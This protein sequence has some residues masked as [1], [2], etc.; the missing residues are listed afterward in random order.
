M[1]ETERGRHTPGP[2]SVE[3]PEPESGLAMVEGPLVLGPERQPVAEVLSADTDE[4]CRFATHDSALIAAAPTMAAYIRRRAAAGDIDAG[5][6]IA[7]LA[8]TEEGADE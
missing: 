8:P 6:I 7:A 5:A 2:W 1:G 4:D 3:W